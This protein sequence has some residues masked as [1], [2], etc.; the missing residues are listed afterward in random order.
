VPDRD[1]PA[2][3]CYG[4]LGVPT[5]A[6]TA[7]IEAAFRAAAKREHPD[8][9]ADAAL[10]TLRM[11]RLNV[12]RDWLVDPE[13]RGRYDA[14]RGVRRIGGAAV[15]LPEI[16]PL[17]AWPGPPDIERRGSMAGPTMASVALMVLITMLFVGAGSLL[18]AAIA[19]AAIV[20]L[21]F[22]VLLTVLGAFR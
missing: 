5:S 19:V 13:R 12:A 2:F 16:D 10:A 1:L 11:Q 9:H 8:L 7:D 17:G 14:A 21:V 3:D 20:V 6:T 18:A 22:G 4:A 15:D